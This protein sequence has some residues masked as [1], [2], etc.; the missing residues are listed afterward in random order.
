M[1]Y[2]MATNAPTIP[3]NNQPT[4][5]PK[6]HTAFLPDESSLAGRFATSTTVH[7][8]STSDPPYSKSVGTLT[9]TSAVIMLSPIGEKVSSE[10]A[11]A[12]LELE[13]P[14]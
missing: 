12:D 7:I 11:L 1:R 2:T 6:I 3:K 4:A 14:Q 8:T 9:P 13:S 5:V 10:V